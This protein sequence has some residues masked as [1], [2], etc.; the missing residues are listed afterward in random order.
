LFSLQKIKQDKVKNLRLVLIITI[1]LSFASGKLHAQFLMDMIDTTSNVGKG[2]L[3]AYKKYDRLKIGGYIQPQFQM[4]SDQGIKSYEGGDFSQEVSN[5]FLLRRSRI[6]FDYFHSKED[7]SPGLQVA[8]QFDAN[9]RSLTVRDVWGRIF[10]NQL[11]LFSFTTGMFARPMGFEVN[12]SSSDREAPERGRM[13]Q[14]LMKSERDLG[15]ELSFDPRREIK[16]FNNLKVDL[17]VFNGQ[18]INATG[19]FDNFKD[20]IASVNSKP[21]K[22]SKRVS[23]SVGAHTLQGGLLQ[24]TQYVYT[25]GTAN[26]IKAT[27]V[28]SSA[29]NLHGKSP[30]IYYGADAQLKIK[31]RAGFSEF[32][33]EFILGQQ[34]GTNT[35]SE[36]PTTLL[37]GHEGYYVR[38]FNGAYF[39]YVQSLFS[40]RH[41]LVF[42]YDWYD[43]NSYVSG[44]EIGVP[45]SNLTA[46]NI[47][48]NTFGMGYVWYITENAKMVLYYARV[49]NE[50]TR[51]KGYESDVSDDVMTFRLQFRF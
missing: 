49:M 44:K 20:F 30:R 45:G 23:L 5:R 3:G 31:N 19:D 9:E 17:G 21:L 7:K 51:L 6:R 27:V 43:P 48:Y 29:S 15:V 10:E 40:T 24:N 36:T 39:Y 28:D 11:K 14:I 38:K 2:I 26:G 16:Y 12:Y 46:A 18:G 25:T 34:T 22:L 47:K 41:Q 50:H 42:K 33:A 4:A 13:S 8:F 35:S 1:F 32:R 37:I